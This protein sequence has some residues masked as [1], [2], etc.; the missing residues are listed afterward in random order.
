M[1]TYLTAATSIHVLIQEKC[2]GCHLKEQNYLSLH[3]LF[4]TFITLVRG[5][6]I[7]LLLNFKF[8]GGFTLTFFP[9]VFRRVSVLVV[10]IIG[11]RGCC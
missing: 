10:T 11:F 7:L 4:L 2:P 8:I 3:G 9:P 1:E 6:P 5:F